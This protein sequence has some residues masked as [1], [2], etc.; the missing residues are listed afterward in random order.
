MSLFSFSK[1]RPVAKPSVAPVVS[2]E[3]VLE[4]AR[5]AR[6][7][8]EWATALTALMRVTDRNSQGAEYHSLLGWALAGA[9]RLE[10]AEA[11]LGRALKASPTEAVHR[12]LDEVK[13]R[14]AA[15]NAHDADRVSWSKVTIGGT[16]LGLSPADALA[17]THVVTEVRPQM[18][19]ELGSCGG[20]AASWL[21]TLA[22]GLG[23]NCE[24]HSADWGLGAQ[25]HT[26]KVKFWAGDL[27]KPSGIWPGSL[28]A[29]L[30]HPIL[31]LVRAVGGYEA[32][33]SA[34]RSLHKSLGKGDVICV[35]A[36]AE[37]ERTSSDALAR[38]SARYPV[39]YGTLQSFE[40]MFGP[41]RAPTTL[42]C[43][44]HTGLDPM[45]PSAST[46]LESIRSLIESGKGTAALEE[47]NARKA[48][49][50]PQRGVDYLRAL[51]FLQARDMGG[52]F[53][54][55][56]E[57]LRYF[58]DHPHAQA[59]L[60]SAL[61]HLF[62]G[63]PKLGD[64]EFHG[65]YGV[66]RPYT[67]LSEERLFSIYKRVKLVCQMDV[68][69]DVVECGVAAGG[70]SALMAATIAKYT[71]RPRKVYACDTFEGMPTPGEHDIHQATGAEAT[72]WGSGT[73]AAPPGSLMEVAEKLG[74]SD[75]VLPVKGLFKDT[76]PGLNAKLPDGVAFLHMDGD[77]YESTM[78]ILQHLYLKVQPRGFIQVDDYGHWEGCRQAMW[79]YAKSLG[80]EFNVHVIDA[81]GVW[82][83]RPDRKDTDLIRLNLGCG[84]HSHRD[85][86]NMDVQPA[87]PS[88]IQ[89]NIAEEPLPFEDRSC[90]VVYHSHVIEHISRQQ[91]HGFV[92]ECFRVLAP[93]G[94]LRMAVTDLEHIARLYLKN[95]DAAAAGD[96][97]ASK[98]HE[99]VTIEMVDPLANEAEGGRM[100]GMWDRVSLSRLLVDAGF[101]NVQVCGAKESAIAGFTNFEL[102][103]D[104]AGEVRKPG[105][106][107]I[108]A[109]RPVQP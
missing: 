100:L 48:S 22:A 76:L 108:E 98:R 92:A 109:S 90:A 87:N 41:D 18:I 37:G 39:E 36:D 74:V 17:L 103:T 13:A 35:V 1:S 68:P 27:R 4:T 24:V 9:G 55:A 31:L 21:A 46:G 104:E 73:C 96:A 67:M 28:R 16:A 88:V 19:L 44:Q 25:D 40:S 11:A 6:S 54:S 79:D 105:S 57:E 12:E 106:L 80:F 99:R 63:K 59:M 97:E 56:K 45:D 58:P 33:G 65:L 7:K 89:H 5:Q 107:F 72:G 86:V 47:L 38:F 66:I 83:Q 101:T 77:W 93:G 30:P 94:V 53:E 20:G 42:H 84:S 8:D 23:I 50:Q 71:K 60:A 62:P 75:I 2:V 49:R 29:S 15:V 43:L 78:D 64:A 69:G 3:E 70:A 26:G 51:C 14:Q 61:R 85:W 102:D 52:V 81:T 91:V 34:L 10:E 82:L 32:T 95:L